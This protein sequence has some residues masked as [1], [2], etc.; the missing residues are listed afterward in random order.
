[1]Q[2]AL[3]RAAQQ[4]QGSFLDKTLKQLRLAEEQ[5]R[6]FE[7]TKQSFTDIGSDRYFLECLPVV[8]KFKGLTLAKLAENW[9]GLLQPFKTCAPE[10]QVEL[11][12]SL[13][14]G[15]RINGDG[16]DPLY[17]QKLR[18]GG[19]GLETVAQ[20][21]SYLMWAIATLMYPSQE[22]AQPFL[23]FMGTRAARLEGTGWPVVCRQIA[24]WLNRPR[25]SP[26]SKKR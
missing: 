3:E 18:E 21:R 1:M 14:S 15:M 10:Q 11:V 23:D 25:P 2:E 26:T 5:R 24:D 6:V 9:H 7:Q 22:E 17:K 12:E 4:N 13:A 16:V 19:H 20:P 8:A